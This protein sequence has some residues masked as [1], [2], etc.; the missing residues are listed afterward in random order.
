MSGYSYNY[1]STQFQNLTYHFSPPTCI[2]LRERQP[3]LA[4][5]F[6]SPPIATRARN[7]QRNPQWQSRAIMQQRQQRAAIDKFQINFALETAKNDTTGRVTRLIRN[8]AGTFDNVYCSNCY[9]V[10]SHRCTYRMVFSQ[11]LDVAHDRLICER[12]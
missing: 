5:T 2:I 4:V 10:T 6:T 9:G 12:A 3:I 11:F 7:M 8:G 1:Y